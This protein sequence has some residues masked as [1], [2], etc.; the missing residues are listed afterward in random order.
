MPP[1]ITGSHWCN[2][3]SDHLL[4][5]A[6]MPDV[7][8]SFAAD[9]LIDEITGKNWE[10]GAQALI[11][12]LA[13]DLSDL[14]VTNTAADT[15]F[16][17]GLKHFDQTPGSRKLKIAFG[18][19]NTDKLLAA[20]DTTYRVYR[21]GTGGTTQDREGVV[22]IVDGCIGY[23][24]L[25]EGQA[26]KGHANEYD[27]WSELDDDGTDNTAAT[28]KSG[29][30][31]RGQEF[32]DVNSDYIACSMPAYGIADEMS[33]FAWVKPTSLTH[34]LHYILGNERSP[35]GG[36]YIKLQAAGTS[37]AVGVFTTGNNNFNMNRGYLSLLDGDFHHVGFV[38]DG[39][40]VQIYADGAPRGAPQALTGNV[41]APIYNTALA[42]TGRFGGYVGGC[43]DGHLDQVR[44]DRDTW[45]PSK[46][47]TYY[48][49]T[50]DNDAFWIVGEEQ[51]E[52][53]MPVIRSRDRITFGGLRG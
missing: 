49:M 9:L 23:W 10:G 50:A 5:A 38:Y 51:A 46:A 17:W 26:G 1:S 4:V 41:L 40:T 48:E 28:G 39:S 15:G 2:I 43:F 53:S 3:V 12:G 47:S 13:P 11:D 20:L 31:A 32:V 19:P 6:D 42:A 45:S 29:Q 35:F 8:G 7:G 30:V 33:L 44:L 24:P 34:N 37:I 21:G 27:D 14:R 16:K 36:F 22:P 25:E 18:V 52:A